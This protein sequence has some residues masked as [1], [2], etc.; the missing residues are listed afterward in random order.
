MDLEFVFSVILLAL[1]CLYM[2][3]AH[4]SHHDVSKSSSA[5]EIN[6]MQNKK[7]PMQKTKA[8]SKRKVVNYGLN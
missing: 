8:E 2:H 3:T 7:L 4:R 5:N 6:T 1:R